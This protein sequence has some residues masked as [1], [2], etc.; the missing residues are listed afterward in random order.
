MAKR[1][2]HRGLRVRE[3]NGKWQAEIRVKQGH[4]AQ[5]FDGYE[6]AFEWGLKQRE[7]LKVGD[8]P[9]LNRKVLDHANINGLI[10]QH[11]HYYNRNWTKRKASYEIEK[12]IFRTFQRV[13]PTLCWKPLSQ[14]T[15]ADFAWHINTRLSSG[16][17]P[18]TVRRELNP[19]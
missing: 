6:D 15:T 4:I 3:R 1:I 11:Y 19:I 18:S 10:E 8:V 7:R 12:S 13:S 2:R 17:A 9:T 16:I 5:S 14:V